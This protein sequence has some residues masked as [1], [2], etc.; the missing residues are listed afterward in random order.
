MSVRLTTLEIDGRGILNSRVVA[1]VSALAAGTAG[2]RG[3]RVQVRTSSRDQGREHRSW[4]QHRGGTAC[5][6][7]RWRRYG[8]VR[9]QPQTPTRRTVSSRL[10]QAHAISF[11]G[12]LRVLPR[13]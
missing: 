1:L 7:E 3:D 2:P 12:D 10:K 4:F 6:D 13:L 11:G 9:S 5:V 8:W